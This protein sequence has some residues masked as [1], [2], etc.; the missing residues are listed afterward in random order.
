MGS[1]ASHAFANAA[2][3]ATLALFATDSETT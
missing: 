1:R 3:A 2:D